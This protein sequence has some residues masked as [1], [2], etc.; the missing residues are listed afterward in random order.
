VYVYERER[1]R[2]RERERERE[3]ERQTERERERER[4]REMF[5]NDS[6][7]RQP[8]VSSTEDVHLEHAHLELNKRFKYH[9]SFL[10]IADKRGQVGIAHFI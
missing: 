2:Q 8:M 9:T 6:N 5:Q 3:R 4:E 1:E 7:V 10:S